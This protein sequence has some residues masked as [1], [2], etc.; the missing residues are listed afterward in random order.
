LKSK[1]ARQFNGA[2]F[3]FLIVSFEFLNRRLGVTGVQMRG[4][5]FGCGHSRLF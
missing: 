3:S 1:N 5:P 2:R 4:G